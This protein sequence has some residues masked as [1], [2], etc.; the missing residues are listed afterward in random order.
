MK[1]AT[2]KIVLT[3][4]GELNKSVI[5]MLKNCRYD[6]INCKVY[7]GYYSGSGRFASAHSAERMLTDILKAQGYKF[8]IGNDAPRGGVSG[9]FAKLSRTAFNFVLKLTR[10]PN[11]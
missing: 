2:E 11:K 9:D 3:K 1:K 6:L 5:N 8:S 10:Q 4:K 7:T